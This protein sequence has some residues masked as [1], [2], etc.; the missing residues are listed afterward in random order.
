MNIIS[1]KHTSDNTEFQTFRNIPEGK[2][3]TTFPY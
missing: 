2:G 3:E 1:Y